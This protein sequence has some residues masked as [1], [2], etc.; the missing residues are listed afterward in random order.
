M[1]L[2]A[3]RYVDR[4][5]V[6]Q[7][8]MAR[9]YRARLTDPPRV[10]AL[11]EIPGGPGSADRIHSESRGA[12]IQRALCAIDGRVPQVFDT[13]VSDSGWFY[14]EMEFIDGEDL[15]ALV[16]R[17]P[18]PV[19]EAVRIAREIFD[20][21]RIAHST[22]VS[23]DGERRDQQLHGDLAPKNI[24]LTREG[25]VKILDFGIAKGLQA[26]ATAVMFGSYGYISP[27]RLRTG[28]MGTSDDFWSAGV[29]LYEMLAGR[30]AFNGSN[31][32]IALALNE[33]RPPLPLGDEIPRA[34]RLIVSK[35]LAWDP[36]FRYPD[37]TA[38][39]TDL[40]AFTNG[41]PTRAET[42]TDDCRTRVVP[43][44]AHSGPAFDV[45][46]DR[47]PIAL[48]AVPALPVEVQPTTRIS[49]AKRRPSSAASKVLRKVVAL[50]AL[51]IVVMI[52][53]HE[54]TIGNEVRDTMR[55]AVADPGNLDELV[56]SYESLRTRA[57]FSGT[58]S[59][60]GEFLSERLVM[61]AATMLKDFRNDDPRLE[62]Q[63]KP[64]AIKLAR[65][66]RINPDNRSARAW[67]RYAQ[68]HLARIDGENARG[69][70]RRQA[71][72]RS[73][74][75][76]EEASRLDSSLPDPYLGLARVYTYLLPDAD[77]ARRAV[78]AAEQR[79]HRPGRREHTELGDL[80]RSAVEDLV[81]QARQ[82]RG[83]ASEEPLLMRARA[84][85]DTAIDE[86]RQ[87]GDYA[88]S[89]RYA[90]DLERAVYVIDARLQSIRAPEIEAV[91]T[92]VAE[93]LPNE[94]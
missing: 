67:L 47:R 77:L 43:A 60:L 52:G 51:G 79:G 3:D 74:S 62:T 35:L 48:P 70:E 65:A 7:G 88:N 34:L 13:Y 93:T 80:S 33:R 36:A 56:R 19:T 16:E 22:T 86:Y 66:A 6:A 68:G 20:F 18:L 12:E 57:W 15:A 45:A 94:Q 9:V 17:G 2:A 78:A 8:G 72:L 76:F 4:E 11:R 59:D 84:E 1:Q 83:T 5:F 58:T 32:E 30:R 89:S 29:V 71:L 92:A 21:L 63:F 27:E 53:A 31:E 25:A 61:D 50:G 90:R 14:V 54:Q 64:A 40:D 85:A 28:R 26:T 38:V 23:V 82:L 75:L 55:M 24:R 42:D 46:Q 10:V 39:L 49:P 81:K 37:A 69:P 73:V 41:E 44:R 87:A 91:D